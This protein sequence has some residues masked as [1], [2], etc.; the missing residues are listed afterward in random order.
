MPTLELQLLLDMLK[1]WQDTDPDL[2]RASL[3]ELVHKKAALEARLSALEEGLVCSNLM[4]ELLTEFVQQLAALKVQRGAA[5]KLVA[6]LKEEEDRAAQIV[7]EGEALELL[8]HEPCFFPGKSVREL[9][10][11]FV[12]RLAVL[13]AQ[14]GAEEELVALLEKKEYRLAER[15]AVLEALELLKQE[16][17]RLAERVA[18]VEALAQLKKEEEEDREAQRAATTT[19]LKPPQPQL[20]LLDV[21]WL[22]PSL[23]LEGYKYEAAAVLATCREAATD[24][25]LLGR[26]AAATYGRK[27]KWRRTRLEHA[28]HIG[29]TRRIAQLLA[30][31]ASVE[32]APGGIPPLTRALL[33]GHVE[34]TYALIAAGASLAR[35]F[36]P[37]RGWPML[38]E[39]D[40]V[41]AAE[42]RKLVHTVAVQ[43]AHFIPAHQIVMVGIGADSVDTVALGMQDQLGMAALYRALDSEFTDELHGEYWGS[44]DGDDV[45]WGF[46]ESDVEKFCEQCSLPVAELLF[47][48][49]AAETRS[50]I[51]YALMYCADMGPPAK[52]LLRSLVSA[53]CPK[54]VPWHEKSRALY[55]AVGTGDLHTVKHFLRCRRVRLGCIWT[56]STPMHRGLWFWNG[57]FTTL[58]FAAENGQHAIMRYIID[59]PPL[60][61]DQH[62]MDA[63][64]VAVA[65]AGDVEYAGRLLAAGA[66]PIEEPDML[67]QSNY[68]S[69]LGAALSNTDTR[70]I[71]LLRAGGAKRSR[72]FDQIR[73]L[74]QKLARNNFETNGL[75]L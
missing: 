3:D 44:S 74:E 22:L 16:P 65:I 68:Q 6:R 24:S 34:A 51:G 53:T 40:P 13:K 27:R 7:A 50:F 71:K 56:E 15:V 70:M 58:T 61:W 37:F 54:L 23:D 32:G 19:P 49:L 28:A 64:L 75:W 46:D 60:R 12:Q 21:A 73:L 41:A 2:A 42:R 33:G 31:G 57:Q 14:R 69:A 48:R 52:K 9:L 10:T 25:R 67:E 4:R 59:H 30:A 11:E 47:P 26:L 66:R 39:L 17:D 1:A 5:E 62:D 29:D 43:W 8:K 63:A 36:G 45:H 35:G 18:V 72:H 20:T 38:P 55:A